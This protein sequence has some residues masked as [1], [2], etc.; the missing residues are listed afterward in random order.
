MLLLWRMLRTVGIAHDS[1]G[2]Q[3]AVGITVMI[4]F[5]MFVN[6][7]MNLGIMPVTGIPLPFI[8]LGGTSLFVTLASIGILQS[9]VM[10][11][12]RLGFQAK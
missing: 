3:L 5:Q 4:F 7:G 9:I 11:H 12:R 8:S 2:Q 6:I 10:N 1:F